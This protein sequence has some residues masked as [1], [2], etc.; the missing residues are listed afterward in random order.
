MNFEKMNLD[1]GIKELI[2]YLNEKKIKTSH[3][4]S[5]HPKDFRAEGM[6][7][8]KTIDDCDK[9]KDLIVNSNIF[10]CI[11]RSN[12]SYPSKKTLYFEYDKNLNQTEIDSLWADLLCTISFNKYLMENKQ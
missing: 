5:G 4:C 12:Y 8:F 6:I 1:R 2:I 11:G 10:N 3:S 9:F 7:V